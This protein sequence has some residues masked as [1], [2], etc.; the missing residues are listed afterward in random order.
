MGTAEATEEF[1][2]TEEEQVEFGEFSGISLE[3]ETDDELI[4]EWYLKSGSIMLFITYSCMLDDEAQE[5]D[6]VES[7]LESLRLLSN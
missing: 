4:R 1:I 6:V 2:K 3:Y 7:I 5:E